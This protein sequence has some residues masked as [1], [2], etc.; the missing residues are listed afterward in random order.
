MTSDEQVCPRCGGKMVRGE[1]RFSGER[2]GS[3]QMSPF[4]AGMPMGGLPNVV[5]SVEGRPYW[6]ERTGERTGFIF[7]R[8]G[9]RRMDLV[10][11]R[12]TL[13]NYVELYARER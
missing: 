6:E 8:Q 12:C 5:D 11:L 1:V 9:K 3:Q 10:G 4:S 13:C 7:K 2:I